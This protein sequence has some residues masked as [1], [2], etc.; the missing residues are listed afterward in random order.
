[1]I[2]KRKN[3]KYILGFILLECPNIIIVKKVISLAIITKKQIMILYLVSSTIFVAAIWSLG[4]NIGPP[5]LSCWTLI[6][7]PLKAQYMN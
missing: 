6:F 5:S 7:E 2:K 4:D 1:V 3:D